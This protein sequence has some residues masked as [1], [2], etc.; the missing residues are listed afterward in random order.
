MPTEKT[1]QGTT[2]KLPEKFHAILT[3]QDWKRLEIA[4]KQKGK[5]NV[6][7]LLTSELYKLER[8]MKELIC[9]CDGKTKK[10]YNHYQIPDELRPFYKQLA[11]MYGTNVS[12]IVFRLI[13][14][15]NIQGID[16]PPDEISEDPVS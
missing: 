5:R 10:R 16:V 14:L 4:A 1:Q 3:E 15:P 6:R 12:A 11:C 2:G 8:D 9:E 13:I 7:R